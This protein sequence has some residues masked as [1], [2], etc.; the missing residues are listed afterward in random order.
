LPKFTAFFFFFLL[1]IGGFSQHSKADS[2]LVLLNRARE[3]SVKVNLQYALAKEF[4]KNGNNSSAASMAT[5]AMELAKKIHFKRGEGKAA[6]LLGN[7]SLDQSQNKKALA[8]YALA[9][10]VLKEIDYKPGVAMAYNNTGNV[11]YYESDF[12][13]ALSYYDSSLS[14]REHIHDKLGMAMSFN[15]MGAIYKNYGSYSRA[16]DFYFKSLKIREE[17]IDKQGQATCYNNIG[18]I[19]RL[20]E[21]YRKA[22]KYNFMSIRINSEIDDKPAIATSYNNIGILFASKGYLLRAVDY[23]Q[24]SIRIDSEIGNQHGIVQGLNNLGNLYT[25][26]YARSDSFLLSCIDSF[27]SPKSANLLK[28]KSLL[29]DT[30]FSHH[31]KAF[32][33]S[34]EIDD[35]TQEIYSLQG[36]GNVMQKRNDFQAAIGFFGKAAS[37]SDTIGA[38]KELGDAA[39]HLYECYTREGKYKEALMAFVQYKKAQDS[40]FSLSN[41]MAGVKYEL[42]YTRD[43][44]EALLKLESEKSEALDKAEKDRQLFINYILLGSLF[45]VSVFSFFLFRDYKRKRSDNVQIRRQNAIIENALKEKEVL[46]KEI[47]HRVK[48]NLQVISSMLNLQSSKADPG[49]EHKALE[50]SK[51]RIDAMALIHELLYARNNFKEIEIKP[52]LEQLTKSIADGYHDSGKTI[53]LEIGCDPL[54]F[55]LDKAIPLGLLINE[56]LT[57]AFKYAFIQSESGIIEIELKQQGEKFRLRITDNGNGFPDDL[58]NRKKRSMGMEL[59]ELLTEQLGGKLQ[60]ESGQGVGYV[61]IF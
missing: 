16:L 6:L 37:L 40:V 11:Y 7:I 1:S 14:I 5:Q 20:Q 53:V 60:V 29:L 9:K 35:K 46:I 26:L 41:R 43:K 34:K 8:Y 33:L 58:E 4:I 12:T 24:K 39:F 54:S 28:Q 30:A 13:K 10:T 2:L 25:D 48:N 47:H 27:V 15:N 49:E 36:M 18:E 55:S 52:Y 19:Y 38:A 3:D 45:F 21:D 61:L 23:F 56:M 51:K 22:L 17:L 31:D 57:N 44:K 50:G 42:D 59:I 32:R